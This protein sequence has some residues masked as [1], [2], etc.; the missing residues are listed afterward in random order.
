MRL[1]TIPLE[2][3]NILK[4]FGAKAGREQL[5]LSMPTFE[6]GRRQVNVRPTR[7]IAA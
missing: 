3:A 4:I 7:L 1:M 2:S 6:K 5:W